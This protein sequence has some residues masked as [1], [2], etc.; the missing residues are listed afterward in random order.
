MKVFHTH[1]FRGEFD[2][3]S[4]L[5]HYDACVAPC[6]KCIVG[7][8]ELC[9]RIPKFGDWVPLAVCDG[10]EKRLHEEMIFNVGK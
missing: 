9:L 6:Q 2:V 1:V 3:G 4:A 8:V 7:R 10:D 5:P